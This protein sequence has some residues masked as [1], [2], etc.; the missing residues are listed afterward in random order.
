MPIRETI[1]LA[2]EA[3]VANKLRAGLTMLGMIIGVGAVV[4]LVSIGNGARNY[5]THEFEGLGTN[6]IMVQPG[7][8]DKKNSF[9]PPIGAAKEKLLPADAEALEKLSLSLQAVTG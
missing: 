1:A 9:A 2:F 4:L 3:L 5:I 8:T 6:L 7:R